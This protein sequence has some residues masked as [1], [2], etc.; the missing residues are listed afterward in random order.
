MTFTPCWNLSFK[1]LDGKK[2]QDEPYAPWQELQQLRMTSLY[3]L[4]ELVFAIAK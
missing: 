2:D 4:V 3:L 1:S